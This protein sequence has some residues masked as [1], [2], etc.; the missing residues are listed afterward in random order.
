MEVARLLYGSDTLV[1]KNHVLTSQAAE[2]TISRVKVRLGKARN[3]NTWK[4]ANI[5]SMNGRID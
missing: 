4:E 2:M 1:E 3:E 5:Y